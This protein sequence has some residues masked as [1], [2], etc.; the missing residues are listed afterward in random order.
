[1]KKG[2]KIIIG[3]VSAIIFF[4][5]VAVGLYF[6]GLTPLNGDETNDHFFASLSICMTDIN[7][8]NWRQPFFVSRKEL[9]NSTYISYDEYRKMID[10]DLA[11]KC[12]LGKLFW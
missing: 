7:G 6:W 9:E 8:K 5:A 2:T 1:M 10:T 4:A 12:F 11:E 3:I